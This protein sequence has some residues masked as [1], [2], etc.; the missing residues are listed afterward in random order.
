[1]EFTTI[2]QYLG[3]IQ[4][5]VFGEGPIADIVA[6]REKRGIGGYF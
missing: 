2:F 5:R 1:M 4:F 3:G 6:D